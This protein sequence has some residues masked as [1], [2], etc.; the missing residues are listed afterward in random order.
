MDLG[1]VVGRAGPSPVGQVF[2]K[3]GEHAADSRVGGE[4][5]TAERPPPGGGGAVM[6]T[7]SD[8]LTSGGREVRVPVPC[9]AWQPQVWDSVWP[10]DRAPEKPRG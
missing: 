5:S 1:A 2:L 9:S 7:P 4:P 6:R 3:R 8:R 10:T